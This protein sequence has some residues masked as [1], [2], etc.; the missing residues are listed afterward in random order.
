MAFMIS[1]D[2]E[3]FHTEGERQSYLFL[4]KISKP[5]SEYKRNRGQE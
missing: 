2:I 4:M 3:V 1:A 5:D